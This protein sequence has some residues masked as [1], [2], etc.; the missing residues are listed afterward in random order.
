[1]IQ[2]KKFITTILLA[3]SLVIP[4]ISAPLVN[5]QVAEAATVQINK[6]KISVYVGKT[7]TL[8]VSGT[9]AKVTW[10]SNDKKVATVASTGKVK[11]IKKGT[12]TI[13]AKVG[14]KSYKCAVTVKNPEISAKS[15]VM[16]VADMEKLSV[17][18][19]IGTVNW[20]SSN[21]SVVS[22]S[23]KG[24]ISAKSIG[25]AKITGTYNDKTYTCAV[26]V[27]DKTLHASVTNLS[28]NEET[29]IIL[30]ADGL[31][32]D[33]YIYNDI[34][35]TSIIKSSWG[36]WVGDDIPL[37][38]TPKKV[39]TTK[40]VI[41]ADNTDEKLI[42]NVT[43][44]EKT[45]PKTG[46]LTAEEVYEKCSA[47][48]VQINT[49]IS[50]GTGFFID[51]GVIVTNYH[52][53]EGA[54]S[55]KV[56]LQNGKEYDIDYILGYDAYLDIAILSVPLETEVLELN[57][58]GVKAGETVYAI[59]SSLGLTDTF[60]DGMVTNINRELEGVNYIQT[61]AAVTNGNS[62][63]PLIN[64]YGEVIGINTMVAEE[65]QNLNFAININ[66]VYEVS[67]ANPVTVEEY[68]ELYLEYLKEYYL[69]EDTALS[70][71]KETCQTVNAE[72][73]A[74]FGTAAKGE[75]DYYKFTIDS[76]TLVEI[77]GKA[78]T[79]SDADLDNL[80]FTLLDANGT[81]VKE[82]EIEYY[83]GY[84]YAIEDVLPAGTYYLSAQLD[85][86]AEASELE[87]GFTLY[88]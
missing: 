65:G 7:Y 10:S 13:T 69:Y 64:A 84:Y 60:T 23:S 8:K 48:T 16:E 67:I 55:I 14:S 12:A 88:N 36:E 9:T 87:Y 73:Y 30:T 20:K 85:S 43:V 3:I 25:T 76:E 2:V 35:N 52:V 62:G 72:K 51:T 38:I 28:L 81:V 58:R 37:T 34:E 53:I 75:T 66:Q 22:V 1:M 59:G 32:E 56:Q 19:A 27:A 61:N 79:E 68:Y 47:A 18:G 54:S 29:T 26:T 50:I 80:K 24:L 11:G 74:I 17:K 15:L 39:G 31:L 57:K 77:Y 82:A 5:Y 45:R 86:G 46:K 42:I 21:K 33:E 71:S 83:Y 63:G 40:I 41:T 4:A 78:Y 70:G 49:D 6:T 44:T